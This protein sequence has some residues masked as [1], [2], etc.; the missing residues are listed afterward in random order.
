MAAIL[1]SLQLESE[2]GLVM[3]EEN[4]EG[5]LADCCQ[6]ALIPSRDGRFENQPS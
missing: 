3:V 4:S 5:T 1:P 2:L 6:R